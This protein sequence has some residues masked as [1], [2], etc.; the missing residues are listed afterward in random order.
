M[1]FN[2]LQLKLFWQ[3]L[4]SLW[5]CVSFYTMLQLLIKSSLLKRLHIN[6]FNNLGGKNGVDSASNNDGG[7]EDIADII[8]DTINEIAN[9]LDNATSVIKQNYN[10]LRDANKTHKEF[11]GG[12]ILVSRYAEQQIGA[13]MNLFSLQKWAKAVNASVVEPFV[14]NSEFRLPFINSP[15]TL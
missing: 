9:G 10:Q 14:I 11:K 4:L 3:S 8:Y 5:A 2:S 7:Q 1:N 6:V 12:V 13:A 15:A